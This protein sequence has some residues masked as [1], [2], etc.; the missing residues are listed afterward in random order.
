MI[1]VEEIIKSIQDADEIEIPEFDFDP[2]FHRL[3]KMED[4]KLPDRIIPMSEMTR[5]VGKTSKTI[6]RWWAVDGTFPKPIILKKQCIGWR[7]SSYNKWLDDAE[8]S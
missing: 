5:L 3:R 7:E 4:L 8:K 6:W 2:C 1:E